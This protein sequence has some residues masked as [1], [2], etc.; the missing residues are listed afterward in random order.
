MNS[1]INRNEIIRKVADALVRA[2]SYTPSGQTNAIKQ[3][4]LCENNSHA[5]WV[6][7]TIVEN[8][9]IAEKQK[10]PLCD[11]T[12]VPH[13]IL[14]VGKSR[15]I[16]GD[17]IEYINEGI[18][19]GLQELPGR[20]MAVKGNV[21]NSLA[22]IDGLYSNPDAVLPAP[23]LLL[24]T[25]ANVLRLNI[26]MQ[27]GG[28][29][30]RAKT[31]RIFHRHDVSVILD[32]IVN[33]G[34]EAVNQL[35]CTPCT[36]AVGIGRSHFEASSMMLLAMANGE[37]ATQN[38]LEKEITNRVNECKVGPLGLG[39]KHSVLATFM[40]M[41]ELRASG[42]RIVCMRPCCCI[43]PRIAKVEF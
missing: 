20:P 1:P 24:P 6:L 26:L 13:L 31:Y 23:L 9:E 7:E 2:S 38:N 30:L 3:A 22:Q 10:R 35:G 37:H 28:P 16:N 43:E 36:L 33:W 42:A 27:G 21:E 29:E 40:K 41:G 39:G 15:A 8:A 14:E 17:I 19:L 25:T 5:K 34:I 32:E 11:D 12:G 18:A 4:I